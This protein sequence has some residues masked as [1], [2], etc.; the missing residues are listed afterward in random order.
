MPLACSQLNG[1]LGWVVTGITTAKKDIWLLISAFL[2]EIPSL[3]HVAGAVVRLIATIAHSRLE[4]NFTLNPPSGPLHTLRATGVVLPSYYYT[5]LLIPTNT[6]YL[7]TPDS[8]Q[9]LVT[10]GEAQ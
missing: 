3:V 9:L 4:R 8:S 10:K 7:L 6:L 2:A 1:S 5:P